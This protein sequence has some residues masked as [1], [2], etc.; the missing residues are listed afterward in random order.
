[1]GETKKKEE[2]IM[3]KFYNG[4]DEFRLS[5][6]TSQQG[7]YMLFK[8]MKNA[9]RKAKKLANKSGTPWMVQKWK[10]KRGKIIGVIKPTKMKILSKKTIISMFKDKGYD[11]N[12]LK[13]PKYQLKDVKL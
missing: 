10:P 5:K 2:K 7:H 9:I 1:M 8:D 4:L 13:S 11:V 12:F 3:G 6:I